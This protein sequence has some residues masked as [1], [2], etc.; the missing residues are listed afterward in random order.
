M[1]IY[2]VRNLI[3]HYSK[4]LLAAYEAAK[5]VKLKPVKPVWP[6]S[7]VY[8]GLMVRSHPAEKKRNEHNGFV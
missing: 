5:E 8:F 2:A 4:K 6:Q 7:N 1:G 3:E